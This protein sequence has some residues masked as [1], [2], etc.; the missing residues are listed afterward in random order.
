MK[1]EAMSG[2]DRLGGDELSNCSARPPCTGG[3]TD[4][5]VAACANLGYPFARRIRDLPF[6]RLYA[7]SPSTA[8]AHL[9]PL[10]GGKINQAMIERNWPDIL[11]KPPLLLLEPSR[12]ARYCGNSPP[13]RDRTNWPRPCA[14]RTKAINYC[15]SR[16]D[17]CSRFLDD[18]R[19]CMSSH[20]DRASGRTATEY[21]FCAGKSFFDGFLNIEMDRDDRLERRR[22]FD[23]A[24]QRAE[25][26]L[27][28]QLFS[29]P[30][31]ESSFQS[32]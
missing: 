3:F 13:I 12:Q 16:W 24:G 20:L 5:V 7:F 25:N 28:T 15:L 6:K 32:P 8:P 31:A 21:C 1:R 14:D 2:P 9:R 30:L 10:I 11:R 4:R 19:L 22:C 18:G 29:R 26:D 27:V 23:D 17:A